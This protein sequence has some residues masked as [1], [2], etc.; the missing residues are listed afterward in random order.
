M[1]ISKSVQGWP[2]D[3][4][5][6]YRLLK[7][8]STWDCSQMVW[9]TTV[10]KWSCRLTD[11]TTTL[12][13]HWLKK[14]HFYCINNT[15]QHWLD[16]LTRAKVEWPLSE[17]ATCWLSHQCQAWAKLDGMISWFDYSTNSYASIKSKSECFGSL[18]SLYKTMQTVEGVPTTD[19]NDQCPN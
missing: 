12:D 8:W 14:Q 1:G 6:R 19:F 3:L 5:G 7:V 4:A 17:C 15:N 16:Q 2:T 10:G 11:L 9:M 18:L 13:E